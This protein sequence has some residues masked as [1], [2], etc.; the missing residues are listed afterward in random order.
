[1]GRSKSLTTSEKSTRYPFDSVVFAGGMI[2]AFNDVQFLDYTFFNNSK[3]SFL[4]I[5]A[6]FMISL[7]IPLPSSSPR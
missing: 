7:R 1:M 3:N 6:S 4:S 2:R 5:P